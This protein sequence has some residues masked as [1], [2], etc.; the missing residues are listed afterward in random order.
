M[1]CRLSDLGSFVSWAT[2]LSNRI[3]NLLPSVLSGGC[4]LAAISASADV[5]DVRP[6]D[7]AVHDQR[8]QTTTSD[9]GRSNCYDGAE[10]GSSDD[11]ARQRVDDS[12]GWRLVRTPN[13]AGGPDAIS[14]MHA[15]GA[16][17]SDI[18]FAGLMF[19]CQGGAIEM[20]IV[21]TR[22]L[23]PGATPQVTIG[24]GATTAKFAANVA[25]PGVL[26]LLPP[27]ATVLA[28]NH[29]RDASE[30]AIG[31]A[32]G[33]DAVHGVIP[34]AGLGTALQALRSSCDTR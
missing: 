25:P 32:N 16:S 12:G 11:R 9:R 18:D 5:P 29:A 13:P 27:A 6:A 2:R 24:A 30:L 28:D 22:P 33:Q 20:A 23:P 4:L 3:P 15:A 19:R 7:G 14:I 31:V 10:A 34:L 8:C 26:V 17:G 21:L 1:A